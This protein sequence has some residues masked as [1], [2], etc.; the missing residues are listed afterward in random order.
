M[1]GK[2][3]MVIS[4]GQA[5][6]NCTDIGG[7]F[8]KAAKI[9]GWKAILCDGKLDPTAASACFRQAVGQ[10]V[11]AIVNSAWDCPIVKAPLK[12]A[13]DAGIKVVGLHAFDCGEITPGEK[14]LFAVR[15]N[16]G[17]LG[18]DQPA[19]WRAWGG[20]M[21]VAAL[22]KA[23][24]GAILYPDDSAEFASFKFMKQGW[25]AKV[26]ELAPD[27]KIIVMP[28]TVSEAGPK[29]GAKV[30]ALILKNPD[31]TAV[32]DAVNPALGFLTGVKQSGRA[33][34]IA[35]VGG[36][37]SQTERDLV[38]SGQIAALIGWPVDWWGFA[39]ADALNSA[40]GG[41]PQGVVG[42]GFS[43]LDKGN[44]YPTGEPFQGQ[45][46]H[47]PDLAAAYS[48]RWGK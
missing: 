41:R 28:W 33:D 3:V 11:D 43:I 9:L 27:T 48:A 8:F 46:D 19:A 32:F 2:T 38:D 17:S 42:I 18:E 13:V 1:P 34:S 47:K 7:G 39:A 45:G 15:L 29:L 5:N 40:F 30:Q 6:D 22:E 26:K 35:L 24:G 25:D 36:H 37:G 16:Y 23:K 12:Q 31:I 20:A 14:N 10:K 21:A 44:L 4:C